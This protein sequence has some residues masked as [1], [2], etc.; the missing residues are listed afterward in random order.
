MTDSELVEVYNEFADKNYYEHLHNNDEETV[1]MLFSGKSPYE[2]IKI[3]Y[4][5]E[6]DTE[7]NYIMQ[8]DSG[9]YLTCDD[10]T[11]AFEV[12]D[13]AAYIYDSGL[14]LHKSEIRDV[15][16]EIEEDEEE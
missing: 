16:E 12:W 3:A 1:N 6:L 14:C 8:C 11:E 13:I 4:E 7:S 10:P 2:I 5:N 9:D 15:L